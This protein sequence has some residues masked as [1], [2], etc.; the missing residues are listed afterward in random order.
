MCCLVRNIARWQMNIDPRVNGDNRGITK[1]LGETLPA[2]LF[3][4]ATSLTLIHAGLISFICFDVR[5]SLY[6]DFTA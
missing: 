6:W 1:N 4:P 5:S 3:L 2:L